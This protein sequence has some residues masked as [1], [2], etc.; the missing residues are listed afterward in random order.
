M[1]NKVLKNPADVYIGTAGWNYPDWKG[2]VYPKP[3][4]KGVHPLTYL[5]TYFNTVEVNSTFYRPAACQNTENWVKLTHNRPGFLFT[6]KLW[7]RFTHQ[8]SSLFTEHETAIVKTGLA[9]L[10]EANKLGALL[11]Q[12]PWSFKDT[13]QNRDWLLRVLDSFSAYPLA[14]EVRHSSWNESGLSK[15]LADRNAAIC[16]IDQPVLHN[17]IEPDS[18]ITS[19]LGYIRLH[20]RNEAD[21]FRDDA[22]RDDRYNYL[23]SEEELEPWI[24]RIKEMRKKTERLIVITNNHYRG[25]AAVNALQLKH[26]VSLNKVKSPLSLL[27]QYSQLKSITEGQEPDGQLSLF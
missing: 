20:G 18:L 11:L 2:I 9:P 15:T 27:R 24:Q 13:E 8:R 5:S 26:G 23:Y 17:S 7:Q 14:I 6:V 3:M 16:N 10:L 25:Q 1:S 4:P 22:G 19:S 12:F 21:W